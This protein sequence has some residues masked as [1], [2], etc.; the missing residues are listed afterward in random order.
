[1]EWELAGLIVCFAAA[2]GVFAFLVE[3][4]RGLPRLAKDRAW[5][6]GIAVGLLAAGCCALLGLGLATLPLP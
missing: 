1:M 6:R 3:Y 4:E 2:G 5:R